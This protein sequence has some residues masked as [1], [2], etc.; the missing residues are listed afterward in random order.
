MQ[1]RNDNQL[2]LKG[3]SGSAMMCRET[4]RHQQY[5]VGSIAAAG[6]TV[7]ELMQW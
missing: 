2:I 5:T 1:S 3:I 7:G 4:I 6:Y